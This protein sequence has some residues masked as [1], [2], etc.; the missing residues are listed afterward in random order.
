[1]RVRTQGVTVIPNAVNG[2]MLR[3]LRGQFDEQEA[4]LARGED[5]PLCHRDP[6]TG[7]M[8]LT[9]L[10]LQDPAFGALLDLPAVMP[11]VERMM[12]ERCGGDS[13]VVLDMADGH[14]HPAG[15]GSDLAWHVDGE[16]VRL[17]LLVDDIEPGGG[18][19]RDSPT[20]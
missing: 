18:G 12:R 20:H 6:A 15:F 5:V 8:S 7:V 17:T 19:E 11:L 13:A 3:R 1:M 16:L 9:N 2:E 14:K 4:R 10:P